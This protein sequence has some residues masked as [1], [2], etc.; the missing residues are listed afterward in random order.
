MKT[1][2]RGFTLVELAIVLVIISLLMGGIL[3]GQELINSAK[4][5]NLANDFRAVSAAYYGYLD[6]FRAVPG[7]DALAVK[8]VGASDKGNGNGRIEGAWNS[9]TATDESYLFWEHVRRAGLLS[10]STAIGTPASFS[11]VNS[12]GGRIG[13]TGDATTATNKPIVDADYTATFWVCS[14]NI[15]GR[16]VKQLDS[17][18]DDGE[19]STGTLRAT[20][21]T[22]GNGV[23]F[24]AMVD[25]TPYIVCVAN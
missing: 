11:P 9:S 6:R 7:D 10:G 24:A 12:E 20:T 19:P 25:T 2:S 1:K 22:N 5:K 4:V 15:N 18:L 14:A 21:A 17:M 13:I 16:L 8:H 23:T 3:K